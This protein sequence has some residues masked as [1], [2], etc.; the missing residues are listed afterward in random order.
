MTGVQTCALPILFPGSWRP[1]WKLVHEARTWEELR[2]D[3]YAPIFVAMAQA[4]LP[5]PGRPPFYC[6]FMVEP[7]PNGELVPHTANIIAITSRFLL[8]TPLKEH[9]EGLKKL[10]GIKL[11][12]GRYDVTQGHVYSNQALTRKLEEYGIPHFAEEYS[13][14]EWDRTW[15]PHGRVEADVLPF[16]AQ[17][18]E[19]AAP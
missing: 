7:G 14:N 8:D 16:F 15:T 5:N 19:G 2:K 17:Y 13:G 12:W 6:D 10:R 18:L 11:D 9:A 1:N 4:Y 3:V